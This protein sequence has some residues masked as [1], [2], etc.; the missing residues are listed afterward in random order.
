M[1][2]IRCRQCGL[3]STDLSVNRVALENLYSS[4][5]YETRKDYYFNNKVINN[6]ISK[7]NELIVDFQKGLST[8][9]KFATGGRLLDLG[10]ALGVFLYLARERGWDTYGVDISEYAA[11]YARNFLGLKAYAGELQEINFPD[12]WF[13]VI[14]LWDIVEHFPDPSCQLREVHRILKND[15]II[16]LNT[17]N[18]EALLR[19]LAHMIFRLTGGLI[20][21]PVKKLYHEY[22]LYYF[23]PATFTELLEAN[24]FKIL[25]LEKKCIPILR[26]RGRPIE[27]LIVR[28]L[29]WPE[30][31]L[32]REYEIWAIAKKCG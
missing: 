31:L 23:T 17:P 6:S 16:F 5:Y 13:D 26:A 32:G 18:G 28:A 8:I 27:R 2:I 15:G 1:Q 24:G 25:A 11:S 22:H 20:S 7:E 4:S 19:L 29:S 30:K 9:E 3:I 14:T 12:G 10:C 21:Y